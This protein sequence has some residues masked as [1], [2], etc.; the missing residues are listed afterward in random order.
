MRTMDHLLP[1]LA[2]AFAAIACVAPAPARVEVPKNLAPEAGERPAMVVSAKGVQIYE[3]RAKAGS[4]SVE[5]V[6]VAPEAD[7][8]DVRGRP[9]GRHGAGPFWEHIDG[10]AVKASVKERANAPIEGAI[11]WLLLAAKEPYGVP[12]RFTHVSSI[13]RVN[14]TGGIA[15]ANGCDPT[16]V[17][18]PARVAYTADYVFFA[19]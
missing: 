9:V 18:S 5:W 17:G 15:P 13:Q 19:R 16:R 4:G 8:F 3:C 12:G 6:F 14:T 11:P 10:S 7:L 2:A 1:V